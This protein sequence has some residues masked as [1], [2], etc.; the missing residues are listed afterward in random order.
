MGCRES[1]PNQGLAFLQGGC[2][3]KG[4]FFPHGCRPGINT[5]S[6]VQLPPAA[7]G[8]MPVPQ[9]SELRVQLPDCAAENRIRGECTF[10]F[11][12]GV[13]YGAVVAATEVS[14]YLV[15]G[16]GRE[17]SRQVHAYLAR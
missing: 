4:D 7:M 16:Q 14:A 15:E 1:S 3:A 11:A 12:A 6:T 8:G 2:V 13:Q 17:L 9:S 10:D 5:I